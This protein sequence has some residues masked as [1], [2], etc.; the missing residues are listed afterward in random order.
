MSSSLGYAILA[1]VATKPQS[2]YD[3]ARQM[4]L[5]LGFYWQAKHGQIYPELAR[6]VEAGQ[7]KFQEFENAVRPP[8]KVY[9]ATPA[10]RSAL[11]KWVAEAP[12]E[13]PNNDELTIKAYALRRIPRT[14]ARSLLTAQVDA[15]QHRLAALEVR[16]S[17]IES[18]N[19][20]GVGLGSVGFGD[21]AAL[22]RAI[23]SEREY[24]AWCRWLLTEVQPPSPTKTSPSRRRASG[25]TR[26]SAIARN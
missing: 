26:R 3:I 7:V 11:A 9:S 14:E 1:L 23:G 17:A 12:Q 22:R 24:V 21:Y 20:G 25:K 2:G 18:R 5:P 15:H 13:R 10:G 6:L 8:R 16:A 4:K 19:P